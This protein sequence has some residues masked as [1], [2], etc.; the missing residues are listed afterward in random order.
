MGF[1]KESGALR[2]TL[3]SEREKPSADKAL[4]PTAQIPERFKTPLETL[5]KNPGSPSA[6]GTSPVFTSVSR[7]EGLFRR[8]ATAA[9]RALGRVG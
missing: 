8:V 4:T 7:S 3:G 9:Q 1:E 2:E 5:G 6:P